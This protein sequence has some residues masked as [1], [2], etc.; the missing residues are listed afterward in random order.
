MKRTTFADP[1]RPSFQ[2]LFAADDAQAARR[3]FALR[4]PFE[5]LEPFLQLR[6]C[7]A[8]AIA[9][10]APHESAVHSNQ[11]LGQL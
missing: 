1:I 6:R 7:G 5:R 11:A 9:K 4:V 8:D 3:A 2:I 10:M